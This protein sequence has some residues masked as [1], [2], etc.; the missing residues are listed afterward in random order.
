[1]LGTSGQQILFLV[2]G[3]QFQE[4]VASSSNH[5]PLHILDLTI[6]DHEDP[7]EMGLNAVPIE[8]T[9]AQSRSIANQS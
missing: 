3:C 7:S 9:R 1:M 4:I 8:R 2:I 6:N 5:A